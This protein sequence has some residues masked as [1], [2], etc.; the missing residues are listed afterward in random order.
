M[1]IVTGSKAAFRNEMED[2]IIP[3]P[4]GLD[5]LRKGKIF[6][7]CR[8]IEPRFLSLLARRLVRVALAL[9][10][11]LFFIVR[12]YILYAI[13]DQLSRSYS[14]THHAEH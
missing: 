8:G 2:K 4:T 3:P 1:I 14:V 9:F 5:I 11:L 13:T 6:F 12:S 7:S 10:R